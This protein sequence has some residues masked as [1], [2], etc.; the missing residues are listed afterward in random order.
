MN[1]LP[2]MASRELSQKIAIPSSNL[3]ILAFTAGIIPFFIG[4]FAAVHGSP[5]TS[6]F[7]P[8]GS[9]FSFFLKILSVSVSHSP[10][11]SNLKP[12]IWYSVAQYN[13]E[14]IIYFLNMLLSLAVSLPH[15]EPS[16]YVSSS[17]CL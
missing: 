4:D 1:T 16:E 14:S 5:Y 7:S 11:K 6:I 10:I 13:T 3:S 12:S 17:N 2:F 9:L 15:A 8:F